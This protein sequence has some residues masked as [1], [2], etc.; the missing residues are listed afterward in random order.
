MLGWVTRPWV[1]NVALLCSSSHPGQLSLAIPLWIGMF[2]TGKSWRI[3]PHDALALYPWSRNVCW[4]VAESYGNNH[5]TR[6]VLRKD[7]TEDQRC[8]KAMSVSLA[9]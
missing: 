3:T 2:T 8:F 5:S 9:W 4:C 1:V 6:P 7:F